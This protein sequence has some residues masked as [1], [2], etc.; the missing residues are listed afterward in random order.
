MDA[1][2]IKNIFIH[3]TAG[4]G[5]KASIEAYWK[6]IGWRSPGYH[7][8]IDKLGV[9]H[10]LSDFDKVVN[11]VRGFNHNSIHISYIG[12]VELVHGKWKAK[13]TRTN[14]QKASIH[15]AIQEAIEWLGENGKNITK[16]LGVMGHRDA[17]PDKNLN[18]MIDSWERIKECPS[19]E[20]QREY[21]YLYS[22]ADRYRSLPKK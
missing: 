17:S 18:G 1:K 22:T 7:I 6:S 9:M 5:N 10:V 20:A 2:N 13:D 19:F 8:L 15:I 4:N 3:C 14:E 16:D 11:G 21:D 12:G